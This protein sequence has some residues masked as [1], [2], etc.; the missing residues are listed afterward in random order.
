MFG[1][2]AGNG[3]RQYGM[4]AMTAGAV[5]FGMT[6]APGSSDIVIIGH[7]LITALSALVPIVMRGLVDMAQAKQGGKPTGADVVAKVTAVAPPVGQ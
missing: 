6:P 3:Y 5:G 2:L 4:G 7:L 1:N